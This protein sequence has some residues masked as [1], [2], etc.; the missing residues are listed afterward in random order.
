MSVDSHSKSAGWFYEDV[1]RRAK[2][3]MTVSVKTNLLCNLI[4]IVLFSSTVLFK[5]VVSH[6]SRNVYPRIKPRHML[7]K[8]G[9]CRGSGVS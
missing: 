7:F 4:P 6:A 5:S 8:E 9:K 3:A 1:T 2:R